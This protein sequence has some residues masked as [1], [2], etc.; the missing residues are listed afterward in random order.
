MERFSSNP[1]MERVSK[2][3]PNELLVMCVFALFV[4][5]I[6]IYA[7]RPFWAYAIFVSSA[8]FIF[9]GTFRDSHAVFLK[10]RWLIAVY[11][12]ALI[13]A[14]PVSVQR[15]AT[16]ILHFGMA[17][18]TIGVAIALTTRQAAWLRGAK[19]AVISFQLVITIFIV[20]V[21]LSD[22]PLER[23]F[24]GASSNVVTSSLIALQVNYLAALYVVKGRIASITTIVT[25]II[26]IVG[27][28]RASML[29]AFLIMTITI[30]Y[31]LPIVLRGLP[32]VRRTALILITIFAAFYSLGALPNAVREDISES[33]GIVTSTKLAS[34]LYD[35]TRETM[36]ME[37]LGNLNIWSIFVG[38]SYDGMAIR[39]TYNG[40]PHN[41]YIRAHHIFGLFYGL[42]IAAITVAGVSSRSQPLPA[43]VFISGLLLILLLRGL[44]ETLVFP[45][46]Y[47]V[48]FFTLC[49]VLLEGTPSQ[50]AAAQSAAASRPVDLETAVR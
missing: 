13:I 3:Q 38:Q 17:T 33:V 5:S 27:Y 21:G 30:I 42:A 16:A 29:T 31:P 44:T 36:L 20:H 15:S 47:D 24:P 50:R 28:G 41:S 10:H 23:L 7:I 49:F 32:F 26:C 2:E 1:E 4:A 8:A 22:F 35:D 46:V 18:V 45:T 37:Y 12:A 48:I 11:V 19:L 40:N 6:F 9:A 43:K 25:L 14:L 39:E 34:G